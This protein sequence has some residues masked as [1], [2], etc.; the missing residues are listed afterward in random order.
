MI[1]CK[2]HVS[3]LYMYTYS[4]GILLKKPVKK[5]ITNLPGLYAH[6]GQYVCILCRPIFLKCRKF[7][8]LKWWGIPENNFTPILDSI[9]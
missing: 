5:V 3:L 4:K 6:V 1:L 7:G 9:G 2:Q 8:C